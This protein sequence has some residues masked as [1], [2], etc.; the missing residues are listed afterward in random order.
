MNEV[1]PETWKGNNLSHPIKVIGVGGGGNNA[2]RNMYEKGIEGVDFVICNTDLQALSDSPISN[3]IQLGVNLTRGLGAGCNPNVGKEA[4]LESLDKIRKVLESNTEMVFIATGLGGGT[5]TGAAPVI[6]KE[7][8]SMEI[9]TVAIVTLPSLDEGEE[10]YQRAING[11]KEL[12]ENVDSLLIIKSEK[13]YEIYSDLSIFEAF[14]KADDIVATAAKSIAEI[15]TV[16]GYINVDFADVKMVMQNSKLALMGHGEAAGDKRAQKAA[17]QALK[18][19]LLNDICISDAKNILV[20]VSSGKKKPLK[21][22]E[23]RELMNYINR[24]SGKGAN[25]KRGVME[26]ELLDAENSEAEISVTIIATGFSMDIAYP[27]VYDEIMNLSKQKGKKPRQGT[28]NDDTITVCVDNDDDDNNI[29]SIS[30]DFDDEDYAN[31]DADNP[32]ESTDV[33]EIGGMSDSTAGKIADPYPAWSSVNR[34]ISG[35]VNTWGAMKE[36][37]ITMLEKIPT[38]ERNNAKIE[39]GRP[40]SSKEVSMHRLDESDGNHILG[41]NN[42]FLDRDV[43]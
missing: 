14:P 27:D 40:T 5:G 36:T 13:L 43:D 1:I 41:E 26:N 33:I 2:V 39:L 42:S 25:F 9:L 15:I 10:P 11:L 35:V 21:T 17:E 12:M 22:A 19:P 16:K 28:G 20:N 24:E 32:D 4:A 30:D 37:D 34:P 38:F 3:K 7:A 31:E 8:K 29:V 6:A 18:S 23:L